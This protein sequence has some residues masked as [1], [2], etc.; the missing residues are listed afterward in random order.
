[1]TQYA[2]IYKS[3]EAF[4]WTTL[5]PEEVQKTISAWDVW[6]RSLGEAAKSGEAF[7]FGGKSV[8]TDG[9]ATADNLLGGF[10]IVEADSFE[11]A[12]KLAA[13]APGVTSGQGSMEVYEILAR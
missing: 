11:A 9:T 4:D 3:R 10:T 2:L 12:E 6:T 1:M 7:K 13:S 8:T 5:P